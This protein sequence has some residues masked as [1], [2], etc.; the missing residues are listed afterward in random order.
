MF[1]YLIKFRKFRRVFK[2][3]RFSMED[4]PINPNKD[5]LSFLKKMST[6]Q[7]TTNY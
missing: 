7:K 1:N 6:I 4:T 3:N 5:F 2:R